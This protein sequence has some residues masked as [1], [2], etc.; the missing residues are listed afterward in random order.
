MKDPLGNSCIR[1]W[2][3]RHGRASVHVEQGQLFTKYLRPTGDPFVDHGYRAGVHITFYGLTNS[4]HESIFHLILG[5]RDAVQQG[6]NESQWLSDRGYPVCL[7]RPDR[8]L[9]CEPAVGTGPWDRRQRTTPAQPG[10]LAVG[11]TG[12]LEK[13]G[14]R[15]TGE[16]CWKGRRITVQCSRLEDAIFATRWRHPLFRSQSWFELLLRQHATREFSEQNKLLAFYTGHPLH[17]QHYVWN[18]ALPWEVTPRSLGGTFREAIRQG[19][20]IPLCLPRCLQNT[21]Q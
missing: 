15:T 12:R 19:V 5:N 9:H 17:R 20:G 8:L 10:L 11:Q 16:Y 3:R 14:F 1:T 2:R 21:S 4:N 6:S 13:R 7:G 18:V